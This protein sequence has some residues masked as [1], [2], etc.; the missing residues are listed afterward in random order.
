MSLILNLFKYWLI[1]KILFLITKILKVIYKK[2]LRKPY[3]LS[4][5]Y[6]KDSYVLITGATNGIGKEFCIQFAKLGYNI[7][8]VSRNLSHL[9]ATSEEI[10]SKYKVK[11]KII[12]YDF[13][14][15]TSL[16]DYIETFENNKELNSLKIRILINNIGISQRELYENY[17]LTDVIDHI[18]VNIVSQSIL[19][20]I[21][22][23]KFLD[24]KEKCAIISMSSFTSEMPLV[25]SSM[26][27]ATKIFD[28][29]LLKS[30]AYE[31]F[32]KSGNN[33]NLIDFLVV[34]PQYVDT[35]SRAGH[36]KEFK[37]ISTE[38]CVTGVLQDLG[39]EI[40]TYGHW[41]HC[42]KGVLAGLLS[43]R[44]RNFA[45]YWGNKDKFKEKTI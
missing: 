25:L 23:K 15:K 33:R 19:T 26:Y 29:Y 41:S 35:P 8:L 40:E 14:K 44:I 11:T 5:R 34:K 18:N 21:Y 2:F 22:L 9:K 32:K 20:N 27:S 28:A 31:N 6:P 17:S 1:L 16:N 38:Q 30:I 39:Y 7:V 24:S 4:T 43:E 36:K 12:E 45:R 13:T 42:V 3:D 37:A 10:E